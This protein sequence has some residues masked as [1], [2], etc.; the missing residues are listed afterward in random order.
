MRPGDDFHHPAGTDLLEFKRGV[1][2]RD[3]RPLTA[4]VTPDLVGLNLTLDIHK[5]LIADLDRTPG[6]HPYLVEKV[7]KGIAPSPPRSGPARC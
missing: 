2:R 4:V 1:G 7:E 6:P 3:A 5:T